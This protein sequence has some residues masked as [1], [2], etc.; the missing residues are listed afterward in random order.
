MREVLAWVAEP[1]EGAADV[2]RFLRRSPEPAYESDAAQFFSTN[3]RTRS[4]ICATIM[5]ALGWLTDE[6]AAAAAGAARDQ[7]RLL[8]GVGG[9]DVAE[10]LEQ[11]GTVYMLGAED[12]Q[13]APLVTALTGHI[14]REARAI[15]GRMPSG[16]LDPPLTL[17][18]DE[19]ALI[20]P[21]PLDNWTADMGGRDV[22]IHIAVQSRA[23]LRQRWGDTGAAAI[24]NNAATVMIYGGTR[25]PDDLAAYSTLT[26]ERDEEVPTHDS[27]G[28]VT[29]LGYRRVPVLSPAQIA[30]LPA[31]R[32]VIIR[33]GMP[34]AIGRVEMAWRRKDVRRVR[35]FERKMRRVE[36]TEAFMARILARIESWAEPGA[37]QPTVLSTTVRREADADGGEL[38]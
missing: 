16:R 34:P 3:D 10:L 12:A 28:Q 24:L 6:I 21:V 31:Q 15:A 20:C 5:P 38:A 1:D 19:A 23:Q 8:N 14:A 25:D 7:I 26:G 37:E 9:F 30:Q 11:C 18:L 33:R 17:A 2:A 36:A 29:A 22:Q 32:V 27:E 13:V 4:S 35:R